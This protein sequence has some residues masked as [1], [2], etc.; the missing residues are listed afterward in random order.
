[1]RADTTFNLFFRHDNDV[2][3]I[4]SLESE[5]DIDQYWVSQR[6][7]HDIGGWEMRYEYE[8][9][10][11]NHI[12]QTHNIK[13]ILELGCGP[14]GLADKIL[15][16]SPDLMYHMVDGKSAEIE[17]SS[18]KNKGKFFVRDLKDS[19]DYSGLESNYD[20][21]ITNDFLE[22]ITNPS[23]ILSTIHKKLTGS[24]SYYFCSSPN[25]R[26]R[27]GFYYPGLFDYDN[28]I[29]FF[30][31]HKFELITQFPSWSTRVPIRTERLD[32]EQTV[33][34]DKLYDWNY[35]LL[36]KKI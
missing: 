35:Y 20:L 2:Q 29:K 13:S 31:I 4:D 5:N 19:F 27:H 32:S 15:T 17:H 11:I 24:N 3:S 8:Q 14:G 33:A 7:L 9:V 16:A 28:L 34:E 12:I 23:L 25:W 6:D 22:H 10:V 36:F 30:L 26:T 1:M 18:R 21:I